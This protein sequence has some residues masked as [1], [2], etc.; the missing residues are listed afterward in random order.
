MELADGGLVDCSPLPPRK[1]EAE[2]VFELGADLGGPGVTPLDV[3]DATRALR[4]GLELPGSKR[5]AP[6]KDVAQ[7]FAD[8]T[9]ARNFVVGPPVLRFRDWP[10][11]GTPTWPPVGLFH[12]HGQEP[13]PMGP[14]CW[15][16]Y[17]RRT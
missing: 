7:F 6:P 14:G 17:A 10:P 16:T 9:T 11:A 1:A 2:I 13:G 12:G 15:G 4:V 5:S 8:N 3:L